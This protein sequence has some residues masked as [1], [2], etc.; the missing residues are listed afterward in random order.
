MITFTNAEVT[1]LRLERAIPPTADVTEGR[2]KHFFKR[3]FDLFI[4]SFVTVFVLSW[5]IPITGFLVRTGSPGPILFVQYRTGAKGR[6][7][8][9]LKFR[10]MNY[11]RNAAFRQATQNDS[12]VTRFGRFLRRTNLDEM[13]QFLNVLMGHMSVV[14]PRP[15]PLPLDAS[16]WYV[17]PRYSE[18]Y[19]VKPGITGLAQARGA[20]GLT[21][22]V[23]RMRHRLRYDLFYIQNYRFEQDLIICWWTILKMIKGDKS[24]W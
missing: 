24:A 10:T 23:M 2:W 1:E 8:R 16:Y 13:P 9:C 19:S 5:M 22:D 3:F 21:D 20:R 7:F 11:E 14:G 4:A 17:L 18:R 15:H 12:R 6:P